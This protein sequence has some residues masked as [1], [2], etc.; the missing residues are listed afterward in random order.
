MEERLQVAEHA[1]S[2][3]DTTLWYGRVI[4]FRALLAIWQDK[5]HDAASFA[6]KALTCLPEEEN[7]WRSICFGAIGEEARLAGRLDVARQRFQDALS[8]CITSNNIPGIRIFQLALADVGSDRGG[9]HEAAERYQQVLNEAGNDLIDKARALL[10]LSRLSYEWNSLDV[11]EQEAQEALDL[12]M[13]LLDEAL[14]V[15]AS[16]VLAR[17]QSAQGEIVQALQLLQA[18]LARLQ[19]TCLQYY[20]RELLMWQARLHLTE[21]DVSAVQRWLSMRMD[22]D[23]KLPLP[24]RVQEELLSVR[25]LLTQVKAQEAL[26]T[27]ERLQNDAQGMGHIRMLLEIQM[28]KV[29]A[30]DALYQRKEAQQLLLEVLS[31]ASSEGYLRLFLDE[32]EVIGNLLR[33]MLPDIREKSLISH[34][35]AIVNAFAQRLTAQGHPSISSPLQEPLSSQE[36]RVLRLLAAGHSRQEI[37]DELVV[38]LNTVKTHLKRIYH[39]L[40]VTNHERACEVA[41]N[42]H[43]L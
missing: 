18:Q 30:Q 11:A 31:Q 26:V 43:L 2:L 37:A 35:L 36:L 22:G 12:G 24:L 34:A 15:Q 41:R 16:L 4:A 28:L 14:Q 1:W 17:I 32:G 25:W 39:K 3:E 10:G 5:P 21:G 33:G 42:L 6:G 13:Q 19:P 40:N 38:S 8:L 9:L 20:R 27:L 23:E 7:E 29:Q